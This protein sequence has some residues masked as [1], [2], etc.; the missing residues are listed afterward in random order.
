[1]R[2]RP[3]A[4]WN[5]KRMFIF[6]FFLAV[7]GIGFYI[8]A[9]RQWLKYIRNEALNVARILVGNA[10]NLDS[11]VLASVSLIQEVELVSRGYRLF[12][13]RIRLSIIMN[14]NGPVEVL[15][16]LQ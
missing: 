1:M 13:L 15:P 8:L 16:C 2:P 11:V 5:I 9:R 7:V 6:V 4:G 10:Q 12:V 3:G 14:A